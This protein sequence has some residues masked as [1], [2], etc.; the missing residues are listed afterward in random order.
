MRALVYVLHMH[1][2]SMEA[3]LLSAQQQQLRQL[4]R[5]Q[6]VGSALGGCA[7]AMNRGL[8]RHASTVA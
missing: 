1:R 4:R 6:Q 8:G 5:L 7:A 3:I 2:R